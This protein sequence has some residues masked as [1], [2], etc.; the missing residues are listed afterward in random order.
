[1]EDYEKYLPKVKEESHPF[2][3]Y[4]E[5][6]E[7]FLGKIEP[8]I[9]QN[10]IVVPPR[11]LAVKLLEKD[12]YVQ[13]MLAKH[14]ALDA[15]KAETG[16][17]V[18]W[19]ENHYGKSSE[20]VIAE[21][22]YGY[23]RGAVREAENFSKH[24]N[25]TISER[26]DNIVMHPFLALPL[27]LLVLYVIF[28]LTFTIGAYPQ[29]WLET[30]FSWLGGLAMR[31]MPDNILRSLLVDGIIAGVG[32]VLSFVPLIV[33]LFFFLSIL[34]DLGYMSRAAF[35]TDKLLHAVGLHG[36]SI[37]PMMLGFGC[38]VP[39]IM[40]SR[41]LKN[42]RDR[43][44]TVL[45]TPMMSCGA[46]LPIHVLIA[47][48]FFGKYAGNYVMLI[49][50]CGVVMSLICAWIL[51]HTVLK[52]EPTPFVLELPP[53]RLPT[54]RGIGYHVWEK[55]SDYLKRAGVI[56]LSASILV[57]VL[58][59]F[60][61]TDVSTAK[62]A[63][64]AAETQLENSFIGRAGRCIQ[65]VFAPLHFNWKLSVAT[66]TGFA[67][68]EVVVSTLN[69][70]YAGGDDETDVEA[71][72]E[73]IRTEDGMSPLIGFAFMLFILLIPPCFSA[74]ATIKGELGWRWL[75]FEFVFLFAVGWLMSFLVVNIGLL[76]V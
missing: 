44:I 32:G 50:A 69:V 48:A 64:V 12:A 17:A 76:A 13:A 26:I 62:D 45:V 58:T 55:T 71:T 2:V 1:M 46:K 38:S 59:Y 72:Q 49:Y 22:R 21:Q 36:Q 5:E 43:I 27:F 4:G 74:L 68:K 20:I 63:R 10:N 7:Q 25:Q 23:I 53:Y 56:I 65:P 6:V 67:A 41:T 75:A 39:A 54:W 34:E 40:A 11:W 73:A 8:I 42:K 51:Q 52:G 66:L 70:L 3:D 9:A 18:R 28:Q 29:D 47:G 31:Y 37:F 19:I 35:A 16:E 57:W 24:E 61:R 15:I 30:F 60:P 14:P 33:I